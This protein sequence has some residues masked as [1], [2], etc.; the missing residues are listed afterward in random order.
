M[1]KKWLTALLS[2]LLPFSFAQA[3]AINPFLEVPAL[4]TVD[5]SQ[6]DQWISFSG[7]DFSDGASVLRFKATTEDQ[8]TIRAYADSMDGQPIATAVFH[9]FTK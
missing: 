3:E 5:A 4:M 8:L 9:S 1:L 7:L 2:L 6:S